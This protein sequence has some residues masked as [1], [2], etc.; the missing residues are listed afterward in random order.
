MKIKKF[1]F[2]FSFFLLVYSCS[3]KEEYLPP[4]FFELQLKNKLSGDDAIEY[5]NKL[6][7]QNVAA[8]SNEIGFYN[9]FKGDAIIYI[10]YYEN[11]ESALIEE[12]RMTEK[13][14]PENSVFFMGEYID[15]EGKKIYRTYGMG[16]THYVF[17]HGKELIWISLG[18]LWA[19]DFL[20]EYLK[21]LKQ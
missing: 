5:V 15:I 9:G 6:H 12:K 19:E 18:T 11:E 20:K 21:Y 10:S 1:L 2:Y 8:D 17:S 16:Q 14:S 3:N 4:D 13:I 7:L